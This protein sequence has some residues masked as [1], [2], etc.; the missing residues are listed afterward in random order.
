MFSAHNY[1]HFTIGI[2]II[3]PC[4]YVLTY[5]YTHSQR[6]HK[7]ENSTSTMIQLNSH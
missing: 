1:G 6:S 2:V 5:T 3:F 7:I 4:N